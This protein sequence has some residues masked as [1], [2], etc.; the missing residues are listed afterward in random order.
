[1]MIECE[2]C[3][4]WKLVYSLRKLSGVQRTSLEKSLSG[5]SLSC[6]SKLQELD[7]APELR[8]FVFCS[9][10][11]MWRPNRTPILYCKVMNLPA[12]GTKSIRNVNSA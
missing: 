8:E 9:N 7:L 11:T 10:A 12:L 3:E 4:L 2:E 1:M 6:G 5:M